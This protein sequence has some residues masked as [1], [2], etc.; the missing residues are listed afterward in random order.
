MVV[1]SLKFKEELI[2]KWLWVHVRKVDM[3]L[4]F[5]RNDRSA[6]HIPPVRNGF[7]LPVR[8]KVGEEAEKFSIVVGSAKL[9]TVLAV[10]RSLVNLSYFC[11][12]LGNGSTGKQCG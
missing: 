12:Y 7:L 6:K 9:R 5:L 1:L 10:K 8:T 3:C 4:V 11:C 2:S